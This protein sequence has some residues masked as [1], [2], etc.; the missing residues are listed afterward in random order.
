MSTSVLTPQAMDTLASEAVEIER[1][2]RAVTETLLRERAERGITYATIAA[3]MGVHPA[4]LP[5]TL[6]LHTN[7]TLRTIARLAFHMG[8][9]ATITFTEIT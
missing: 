5:R 8:L 4:N 6:T 2:Q 7:L 9:R 3:G 1:L